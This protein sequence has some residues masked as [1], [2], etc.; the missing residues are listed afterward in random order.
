MLIWLYSS[1]WALSNWQLFSKIKFS[2]KDEYLV[3]LEHTRKSKGYPEKR[4]PE[5]FEAWKH[6]WNNYIIFKGDNFEGRSA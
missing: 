6:L 3:T 1:D 4:V 2:W 5:V